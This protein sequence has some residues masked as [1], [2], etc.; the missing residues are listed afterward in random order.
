MDLVTGVTTISSGL[1]LAEDNG[2]KLM[3]FYFF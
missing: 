2:A 1:R 3:S